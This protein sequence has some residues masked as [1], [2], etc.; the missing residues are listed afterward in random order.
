VRFVVSELLVPAR[1][2]TPFEQAFALRTLLLGSPE[3]AEVA[4]VLGELTRAQ[5]PDGS[6]PSS[7]SLRIPPPDVVEPDAFA[8]WVDGAFGGGSIQVDWAGCFTS[9]AVL[10]ALCCAEEHDALP[11]RDRGAAPDRAVVEHG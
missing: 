4:W 6:W 8:G 1:V 9:A 11:H 10:V 3:S 2:L 5:R 7:A